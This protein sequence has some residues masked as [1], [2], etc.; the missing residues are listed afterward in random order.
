MKRDARTD[1]AVKVIHFAIHSGL[2]SN[3]RQIPSQVGHHD[4]QTSLGESSLMGR[5]VH[6]EKRI[7]TPSGVRDE[8]GEGGMVR[9]RGLIVLLGI[10]D[11]GLDVLQR[12]ADIIDGSVEKDTNRD[13]RQ[14][15]PQEHDRA[16]DGL[17]SFKNQG[18]V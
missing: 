16:D 14:G 3:G 17:E 4:L 1:F 11:N 7:T 12:C 13:E 15:I 10:D 9:V 2:G 5:S 18:V 8:I 6:E